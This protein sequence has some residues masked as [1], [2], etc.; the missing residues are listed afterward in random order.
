M[1]IWG[2][3]AATK[4]IFYSSW[5]VHLHP[6]HPPCLRHCSLDV[7]A[8]RTH[9]TAARYAIRSVLA[10]VGGVVITGAVEA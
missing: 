6:V 10:D 7:E 3:P 8:A 4:R 2:N 9:Q 1:G 5:G